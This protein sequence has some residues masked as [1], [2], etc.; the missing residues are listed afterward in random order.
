MEEQEEHE[1]EEYGG[2]TNMP[3]GRAVNVDL[4]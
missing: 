3:E 2:R 1:L 4:M